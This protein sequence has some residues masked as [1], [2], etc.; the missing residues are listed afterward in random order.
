MPTINI[1]RS[2]VTVEEVSAV[3]R[4]KLRSLTFG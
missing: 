1:P 3:L 4:N 2:Y